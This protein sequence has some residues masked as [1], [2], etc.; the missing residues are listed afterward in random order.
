MTISVR[1]F[2]LSDDPW[3]LPR[4]LY[5]V[6]VRLPYPLGGDGIVRIRWRRVPLLPFVVY[7]WAGDR[8]LFWLWW[9]TRRP[10][11][12]LADGL[13]LDPIVVA[14]RASRGL[15]PGRWDE[16]FWRALGGEEHADRIDSA[17]RAAETVRLTSSRDHRGH[18][19]LFDREDAS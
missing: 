14:E 12:W 10:V 16:P 5:P 17:A 7:L 1:D 6:V 18:G 4:V 13:G 15:P 9:Q 11:Y 2:I 8:V 3:R 19:C